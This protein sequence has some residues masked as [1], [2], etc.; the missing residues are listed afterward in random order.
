MKDRN[1]VIDLII[2]QEKQLF[3]RKDE[4]SILSNL[5]DNEFIEFGSSGKIH[6]KKDTIHWLQ[7]ND[8]TEIEGMRFDASFLAENIIL[9]TYV[10]ISKTPTKKTTNQTLRSSIWRCMG[11]RWR[12]IFHQGT[13]INKDIEM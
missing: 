10:S 3:L 13:S 2:R 6:N 11:G 1:E 9:L 8:P 5:I 7:S 4:L 12:M